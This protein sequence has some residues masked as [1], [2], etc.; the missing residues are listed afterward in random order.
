MAHERMDRLLGEVYEFRS[1]LS[2]PASEFGSGHPFLTFRDVFYNY[3]VPDALGGLLNSTDADRDAGDVKRGDVF[4]GRL[5][6]TSRI[7]RSRLSARALC[8][9]LL[10][11]SAMFWPSSTGPS[12][13]WRQA[14]KRCRL[15]WQPES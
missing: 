5:A 8:R 12:P 15:K 3:F 4:R 9:L 2:K 1:G 11:A 10:S 14:P 6:D 13:S 7:T